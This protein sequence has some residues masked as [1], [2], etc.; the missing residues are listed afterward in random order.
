MSSYIQS[1]PFK[2]IVGEARKEFWLYKALISELSKPL[3]ALVNGPMREAQEGFVEWDDID[4]E[5]FRRFVDFVY[6][7]DYP[8]PGPGVVDEQIGVSEVGAFFCA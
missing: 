1:P 6:T 7:G 3:N 8:S 2:F 5:T 4:E